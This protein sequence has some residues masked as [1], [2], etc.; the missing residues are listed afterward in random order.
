MASPREK[1]GKMGRKNW[2]DKKA[3]RKADRQTGTKTSRQKGRQ[4]EVLSD[5]HFYRTQNRM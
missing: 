4:E 3:E 5:G 1:K 2:E